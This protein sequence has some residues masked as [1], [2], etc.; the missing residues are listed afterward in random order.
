MLP[1]TAMKNKS[2][3]LFMNKISCFFSLL[4]VLSSGIS[5]QETLSLSLAIEN[6]LKNNFFISTVRI[7]E[8]IA[9]NNNTLGNAGFL[10][11]LDLS[12]G[13]STTTN[14]TEQEYSNSEIIK[15]KGVQTDNLNAG[16]RLN[17]TLFDGLRMFAAKSRLNQEEE[18]SGLYLKVEIENTV[19][20]VIGIYF[21][22][23]RILQQIKVLEENIKIYE[24]RELIAK[25]RF[26]IGSASRLEFL[27]AKVDRNEKLSEILSLKQEYNTSI[28]DLNRLMGK[29]EIA[30]HNLS[31]SVTINYSPTY[32]ELRKTVLNNNSEINLSSKYAGISESTVREIQSQRFPQLHL[33]INY[34]FSRIE[35]EAGFTLLND[36]RGLTTGLLLSWNLF[37][38]FN[39]AREIKNAKLNLQTTQMILADTR[40]KIDRDLFV[41]FKRFQSEKEILRLEESNLEFARENVTVALEAY[42]LG[43]ISGL[44]LKEAQ[45]S[46]ESSFSRLAEAR[47]RTKLS[48]TEL[49]RLNGD[50]VK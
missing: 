45:N 49:M 26:D 32:E 11:S 20:Q 22:A 21:N 28:A 33:N 46:Y 18:A 10:P 17:W 42:R 36:N 48:E 38:G 47:Y 29:T 50:L 13:I 27:Q 25:T 30:E 16:A 39:T 6:T 37:N 31:D 5:A 43:S 23:V 15:Q 35:N 4:M 24:D 19:E 7:D 9:K 14:N 44:Q 2:T 8:Q 1:G 40:S 34:N 3:V 12:A 41:A